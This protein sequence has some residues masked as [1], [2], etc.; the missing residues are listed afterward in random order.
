MYENYLYNIQKVS[1]YVTFEQ[2]PLSLL[3]AAS[4]IYIIPEP[5][6]NEGLSWFWKLQFPKTFVI[7]LFNNKKLVVKETN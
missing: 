4:D 6:S 2:I 5:K 1:N 7:C 3:P